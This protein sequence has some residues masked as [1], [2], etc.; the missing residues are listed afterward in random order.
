ML[1]HYNLYK[2]TYYIQSIISIHDC[3]AKFSYECSMQHIVSSLPT[4][5][6]D[7]AKFDLFNAQVGLHHPHLPFPILEWQGESNERSK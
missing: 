2:N 6:Q 1:M 3:N 7:T 4:N 5:R